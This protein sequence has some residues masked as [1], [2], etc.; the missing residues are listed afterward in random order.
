MTSGNNEGD[1]RL[2]MKVT[3]EMP[4]EFH[5]LSLT[6][7]ASEAKQLGVT[8]NTFIHCCEVSD[9]KEI[10]I[11]RAADGYKVEEENAEG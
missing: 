3:I 10:K 2:E 5:T 9:G 6:A 1:V 4:D 8:V 11:L 7:I